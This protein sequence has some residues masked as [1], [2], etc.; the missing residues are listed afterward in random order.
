MQSKSQTAVAR[1]TSWL[2]I[3][4]NVEAKQYNDKN[5][6]NKNS[7]WR[8]SA[9]PY[10]MHK[11]QSTATS[12]LKMKISVNM[13]YEWWWRL[14]SRIMNAK[15]QVRW[16]MRATKA[17]SLVCW[18]IKNGSFQPH[19]FLRRHGLEGSVVGAD[20]PDNTPL[21][22]LSYWA[23]HY[24]SVAQHMPQL[25]DSTGLFRDVHNRGLRGFC[26]AVWER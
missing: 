9:D 10:H 1:A 23:H 25:D 21:P 17:C 3:I 22:L 26:E 19:I 15:R 14:A 18:A 8:T 11:I 24:T 7:K 4:L 2:A 6:Q 5:A 12:M 16:V 13:S 20:C